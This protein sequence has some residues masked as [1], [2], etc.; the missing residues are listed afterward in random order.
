MHP[1]VG[2][3]MAYFYSIFPCKVYQKEVPTNIVT[4]SLYFPTTSDFDSN[5]TLSTFK[6][7]YTLSV[8][9]FHKNSITAKEAADI[10]ADT[11]RRKRNIIPLL[12]AD[13]TATGDYIRVSRIESRIGDSAVASIILTW[14]SHYYYDKAE[15]QAFENFNIDSGVK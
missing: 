1:E 11:V 5:D 8:K 2:S 4:P 15:V 13:G 12:N 14:D 3:I 10:I 9:L 7:T 6:K